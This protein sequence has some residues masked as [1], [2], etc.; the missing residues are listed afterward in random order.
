[1]A[2]ISGEN[3]Y[4]LIRRLLV[5]KLRVNRKAHASDDCVCVTC[6]CALHVY[7]DCD[8]AYD[9]E[10]SVCGYVLSVNGYVHSWCEVRWVM[11]LRCANV[12]MNAHCMALLLY[13]YVCATLH[14]YDYESNYDGL[15]QDHCAI[16]S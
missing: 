10:P 14:G 8:C 7:H 12:P 9:C 3:T 6:G 15:H 4:G 2:T 13:V 16:S 5:S 1:M 11:L